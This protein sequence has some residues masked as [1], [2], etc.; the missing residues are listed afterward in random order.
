MEAWEKVFLNQSAFFESVHGRFG[1]I[2][3]HGGS[4]GG[5]APIEVAHEGLVREPA[6]AEA[7][8]A[9]HPEQVGREAHSLHFNLTGY[10]TTLSVRSAPDKMAQLEV[11][12]ANHCDTCHTS[13]GQCH[14]SRPSNLGGGLLAGHEFQKT[15][16]TDLTCAGC[17]GSRIENE[18]KG[19]VEGA[20]A[21]VHWA[22]GG[23]PC[24]GCHTTYE[25]HG[26]IADVENR[27]DSPPAPSCQETGCH[28]SVAPGDGIAF[29]AD[30][31]LE[32]M[33]CQVCHST[34]YK[35]CYGCHVAQQD[36]IPF[37]QVEPSQLDFKIGRNTLQSEERPW[38]YVPVLHVP[39]TPDSFDYYGSNLLP[40]FDA[41]PT[42]K[43]VTPHNIQRFT[44]QTESCNACHGNSELFLTASDVTPDEQEANRD[45]IVEEIPVPMP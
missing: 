36:G 4:A 40:N 11:M 13:C 28:D 18:Y 19:K 32:A 23:M 8:G 20:S 3:C 29:H 44:P 27:Y 33:S 10:R 43:Y 2:T 38:E 12:M 16:P 39:I 42:W 7:C 6:S 5:V 45:V 37:Y 35:N 31:H 1:C 26:T 25:L 9:C 15:P 22:Q 30:F 21:D 14:V 34:S 41:L 17:H 24:Y